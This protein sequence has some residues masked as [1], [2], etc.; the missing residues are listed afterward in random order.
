MIR[1]VLLKCLLL[2]TASAMA[3][4]I[5]VNNIDE[6]NA[7]NK[8]AQPGD[9]II[10]KNGEWKDVII[11]LNCTGTAAK[12][13][14]FKAETPGKVLITGNSQL[15]LGG[16]YITVEGLNFINGY[17]GDN[18]AVIDFRIDSKQLANHC[19][20][21]NT[22]IDDFNNPKRMDDNNWVSF[23]GKNN[24]LDHCSFRNKKNMGV[25][26]AVILDDDRSREN[27]HS[28]D[29]NY[30]GRRIPLASN[31]GE[32]IRVG[33]SQH[34]QF[35]SNTQIIDNYFEECDGETE[36]VSIK[37]GSNMVRGNLFYASQG[38][39]VLRHGDNNTVENNLFYG[40][41]KEGTGG[42]RVINAGQWV[43]NNFFY[44]CRG[45]D[46][47][48][49]LSLMN[50][51][52]NS[53]AFRYV[54]VTDA[55]I[56]NNTFYDCSPASFCEGS[57]TERTLPPASSVIADNI[58]YNQKDTAIY[59]IFDDISG[60]SFRGNEVS[61]RI[62]QQLENGFIKTSL[63]VQKNDNRPFP[64]SQS[65]NTKTAGDAL[66]QAAIKRLGHTLANRPGFTDLQLIK[67][68]QANAF[69][70]CG[71]GWFKKTP[72]P[73]KKATAVNCATI[74]DIYR[75]LQTADPVVINLTAKSYTLSAPFV[76]T[77]PVTFT[78]SSKTPVLINTGNIQS[79]FILAGN[80]RLSLKQLQVN[81]SGIKAGQ[82]ISND[83]SGAS[84]HYNLELNHLSL[85]GLDRANGCGNIFFAYKY[86]VADSI[87][88][89][90]SSFV[91]N[92]CNGFLL[93][94][95]KD[96]K[97]YYSAEKIVITGNTF[98]SQNGILL[99]IYRGGN[100]ESTM[101]P[102]L[103]F[104]N[105][106]ITNSVAPGN[107]ALIRLTGVQVSNLAG[108]QFLKSNAGSTLVLYKDALRARHLFEKNTVTGSGNIEKDRFVMENN[109]TIQ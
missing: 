74:E 42:V 3:G 106:K 40:N 66:Q 60:I 49:P 14:V 13:I 25:L 1:L 61:N 21:T 8:K 82:F 108:N 30:F 19:R 15:R 38:G 33:V 80:G 55:V 27:F 72:I 47:R 52:P 35:N 96:N 57:D 32:I 4:T 54:Q 87:V 90:N 43:V 105:N 16:T 45:I 2:L 73:S 78:S 70:A 104:S 97:G 22:V 103:R 71:A 41:Y 89:R 95:E 29:H 24:R 77:K 98:T 69:T 81:G 50:G 99:D 46:F 18:K 107:E 75:Q 63:S 67:K 51:I 44:A 7:A 53:P 65:N 6:L 56:A 17:S 86:M 20:V 5:V 76:I 92:N 58:F 102:N 48:S 91:N 28:I 59:R 39:V 10:L 11:R 64:V 79:V 83:S 101:G 94:D 85:T 31:G 37:S 62:P 23:S 12:P 84:N 26:L 100:D 34:C 109:N 9:I 88:I 93:N 68:I 36:I